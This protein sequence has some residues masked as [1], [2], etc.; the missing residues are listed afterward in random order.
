MELPFDEEHYGLS[1]VLG[2]A[3]VTMRELGGLYAMLANKGVWR[4]IR[5]FAGQDLKSAVPLLSPE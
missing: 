4:Q 5:L 3:E 2:G 1:L